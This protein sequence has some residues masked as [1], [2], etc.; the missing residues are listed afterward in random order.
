MK[1][2]KS[3]ILYFHGSPGL[4][5]TYLLR[6]IF[7]RKVGDYPHEFEA[8]VKALKI[9]VL[10]FNRYVCTGSPYNFINGGNS[11]RDHN[12]PLKKCIAETTNPKLLKER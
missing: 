8:D 6:E 12:F 3:E 7:S 10:D 5:K 11:T 1:S 9:L 2:G 4:G